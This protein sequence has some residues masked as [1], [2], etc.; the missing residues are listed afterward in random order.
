MTAESADPGGTKLIFASANAAEK[1]RR[2]KAERDEFLRRPTELM[3]DLAELRA[4]LRVLDLAA[5]TGDQTVMAARRVGPAGYVLAADI[6]A[7]MLKLAVEVAQEEGLTNVETRVMDAEQIDLETDSFDAV[8]CRL[9]LML[10]PDP[11]KTLKELHC[12]LRPGGKL[13]AIVFSTAEKNPYQGIPIEILSRLGSVPPPMFAL[14]QPGVLE[15]HLRRAGFTRVAVHVVG[16]QRHFPSTADV[17]GRIKDASF[18][19]GPMEK[20]SDTDREQAWM[21]IE[22]RLRGFE[23]PD[24]FEVR[25]EYLVGVGTK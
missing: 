13:S 25:G 7:N 6:S 18:L 4:G 16:V 21:E 3:L 24:G 5:G 8:I 23:N 1:W 2:G 12:V 11:P 10:F 14:A 20:L 9:G 22:K 19:R 17:L 15:N